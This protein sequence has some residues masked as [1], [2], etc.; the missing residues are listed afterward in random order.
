LRDSVIATAQAEVE[1][2]EMAY[3]RNM[4]AGASLIG[5]AEAAHLLRKTS[6]KR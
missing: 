2:L 3:Y 1:H 6:T 5:Q 4:V